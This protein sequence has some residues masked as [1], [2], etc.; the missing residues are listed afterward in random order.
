MS[1]MI[2]SQVT[3]WNARKFHIVVKLV[4][5]LTFISDDLCITFKYLLWIGVFMLC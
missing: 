3:Y 4:I 1:Y 5:K 2:I